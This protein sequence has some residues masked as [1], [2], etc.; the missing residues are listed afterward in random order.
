MLT[1]SYVAHSLGRTDR[2]STS[3]ARCVSKLDEQ[4]AECTGFCEREGKD[5]GAARVDL[6]VRRFH[7]CRGSRPLSWVHVSIELYYQV[8]PNMTAQVS[9]SGRELDPLLG[10][11][12]GLLSRFLGVRVTGAVGA[13]WRALDRWHGRDVANHGDLR[14]AQ[15]ELG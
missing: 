5:V 6:D 10:S 8:A 7:G 11:V 15:S 9:R 3:Y 13:P 2:K 14:R 4:F 12:A 1:S